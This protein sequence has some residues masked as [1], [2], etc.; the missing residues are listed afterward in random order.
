MGVDVVPL[1][2][3]LCL[4]LC[5]CLSLFLC[6]YLCLSPYLYQYLHL[7][8]YLPEQQRH[9][10]G[11]GRRVQGP[12]EPEAGGAAGQPAGG[13]GQAGAHAALYR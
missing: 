3:S 2:L 4:S 5:L 11:G 7:G 13:D 9:Q 8:L 6:F 10:Q 12:A 1:S